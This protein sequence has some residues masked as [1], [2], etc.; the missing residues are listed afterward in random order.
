MSLRR[1]WWIASYPKS[2][3]TWL[4][5]LLANYLRNEGG[6]I[7]I[8]SLEASVASAREAFDE[9]VGVEASDLTLEEID[10][11]RPV[12][13]REV[14]RRAIGP[15]YMKV[16]DAYC[17]VPA[18]GA[19][20]P[21]DVT[22]GVIYL[23]RNPLDVAVSFAHHAA[24]PFE[25]AVGWMND[26]DC[27]MAADPAEIGTQ[28]RQR[29]LTWSGHVN[30]WTQDLDAPVLV[31]RYEDLLQ[32]TF[33]AF[34][35][36]VRFLQ[37]DLDP[38]RVSRAVTASAFETLSQQERL[39]GFVERMPVSGT[40]FRRGIAGAWRDELPSGLADKVIRDHA[41]VMRQFGYLPASSEP[42]A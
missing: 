3:N 18:V 15:V 5:V 13:Y 14:A 39:S 28:L 30:S 22:A 41:L 6:P 4:R 17:R 19:M 33:A 23:I 35:A 12:A 27:S 2:G 36:V 38:S 21:P 9:H 1:I 25:T 40:F 24:V 37:L 34:S 11:L 16:H 31:V 10:R 7:D 20:F 29:L 42:P 32:D 26:P 8:N